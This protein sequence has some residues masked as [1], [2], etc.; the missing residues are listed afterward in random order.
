MKSCASHFPSDCT[1]PEDP[2]SEVGKR[3]LRQDSAT[4]FG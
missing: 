1:G 4:S 3:A 2:G